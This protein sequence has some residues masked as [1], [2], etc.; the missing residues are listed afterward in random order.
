MQ[1]ENFEKL[2]G[3]AFFGLQFRGGTFLE[4]Q[5]NHLGKQS[6]RDLSRFGLSLGY[7]F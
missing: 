6:D 5:Y 7:R 1:N 2:G 4:L 3:K